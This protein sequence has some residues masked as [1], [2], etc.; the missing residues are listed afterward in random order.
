MKTQTK[1]HCSIS[2]N[3]REEKVHVYRDTHWVQQTIY[4]NFQGEQIVESLVK[5]TQLLY[6]VRSGNKIH[7]PAVSNILIAPLQFSAKVILQAGG[8]VIASC[9]APLI[10]NTCWFKHSLQ[11]RS[12]N[13][14]LSFLENWK[15][16]G[17]HFTSYFWYDKEIRRK[18][19]FSSSVLF[20]KPCHQIATLICTLLFFHR[21]KEKRQ[22]DK[23]EGNIFTLLFRIS[24]WYW[25][26]IISGQSNAQYKRWCCILLTNCFWATAKAVMWARELWH[27]ALGP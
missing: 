15:N 13:S 23:K 4:P 7:N 1:T 17:R 22:R 5:P 18:V 19:H 27:R 9:P 8:E 21:N 10:P 6:A 26:K 24:P 2:S 14:F 11:R 3:S 20:L 16:N 12:C 25:E